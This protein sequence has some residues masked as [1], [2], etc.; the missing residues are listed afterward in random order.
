MWT[1]FAVK[2]ISFV[3]RLN[4]FKSNVKTGLA[5]RLP[6]LDWPVWPPREG[7]RNRDESNEHLHKRCRW[8]EVPL[9]LNQNETESYS[10]RKRT[11]ATMIE[12]IN[13]ITTKKIELR[14]LAAIDSC[15][16]LVSPRQHDIGNTWTQGSH[17]RNNKCAI[18]TSLVRLS[19]SQSC[20]TGRKTVD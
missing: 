15:F 18:F 14:I 3:I 16:G 5:G 1:V 12:G 8:R 19:L 7:E 20:V 4:L 2:H 9:S 11:K 17:K 6:F 10:H 13:R